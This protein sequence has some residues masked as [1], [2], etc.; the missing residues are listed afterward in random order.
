MVGVQD[1]DVADRL[2]VTGGN[3]A[4][5]LLADNHALGIVAVHL[6]GDFLDVQDDVGDI[7]ANARDR[8]ELVQNAVDLDSRDGCTTKRRQENATQSV[9]QRQTEATL[10]RLGNEGRLGAAGGGEFHLV[11]LD[12][13]LPI[14]LNHDF[15][16]R[17]P[18]PF[19]RDGR[20]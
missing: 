12:Q 1:L 20:I 8:R 17:S 19:N 3:D 14:L 4:R 9:T 6:D 5:T 7:F 13:F 16:F 11:R 18:S 10:E 15:T 2:D